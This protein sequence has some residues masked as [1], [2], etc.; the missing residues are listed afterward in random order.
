MFLFS[1]YCCFSLCRVL[2]LLLVVDADVDGDGDG[3]DE[4]LFVW[5]RRLKKRSF[6]DSRL[7]S[8]EGAVC[9]A[10]FESC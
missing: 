3:E 8:G 7:H 1:A 10:W 2:V 4:V 6:N 9:V 5:N